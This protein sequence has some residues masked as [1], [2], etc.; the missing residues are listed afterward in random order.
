M[1]A[2]VGPSG[3]VSATTRYRFLADFSG[4]KRTSSETAP[5]IAPDIRGV[6][7]DVDDL[8][9]V[10][11]K[12]P[13]TIRRD[14]HRKPQSLP[15]RLKIPGS[16]ALLW[17]G[18]DVLSWLHGYSTTRRRGRPRKSETRRPLAQQDGN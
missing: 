18:E 7:L 13:A 15:P 12:S 3:H 1:P 16:S 14:I 6:V 9:Q 17:L 11:H 4:M 10:L 8:A 5:I 2:K